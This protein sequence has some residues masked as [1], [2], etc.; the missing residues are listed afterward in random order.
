MRAM[1]L[2]GAVTCLLF[3][4]ACSSVEHQG[5]DAAPAGAPASATP[6][7]AQ[8]TPPPVTPASTEAADAPLVLGPDGFG[9]LKMGMTKEQAEATG[10]LEPFKVGGARDDCLVARLRAAPAG[11]AVVFVYQ[12]LGVVSISAGPTVKT[13]EGVGIGTSGAQAKRAYKNWYRVDLNP[14]PKGDYEQA[15]VK[16]TDETRYRIAVLGGK[17]DSLALQD[18]SNHCYP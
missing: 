3:A 5:G 4:A 6:T 11:Q 16:V 7:S 15:L 9:A 14:T 12:K 13:P 18:V 17:V 8:T 1:P 2:V 10:M